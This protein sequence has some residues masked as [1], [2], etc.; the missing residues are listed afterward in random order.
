MMNLSYRIYHVWKRN[1]VSYKRYIIPTL[2]VSLG[3]PLFFLL[4][5]GVGLG[6]YIGGFG[7]ISY[8][9]FL[10]S[11][12][13]IIS[14]LFSAT[15]E[16]LY[17]TFVRMV[18][19]KLFSALIVTPVSCEDIVAGEIA[20][21]MTRAGISGVLMYVIALFLGVAPT[22]PII[23]I[24]LFLLVLSVGFVFSSFS[25]IVTSFAPHIDFFSYY[26][27]LFITPMFFFSGI[28]FP[29][30][31]MPDVVKMASSFIPL[32]HAVI[33]SRALFMEM[34]YPNLIWHFL[35]LLIPGII[36]FYI[37]LIFMKRRIIK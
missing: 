9:K 34:V 17:G 21:G 1:L 23:V 3:E 14:A 8:L 33:I 36:A 37:A 10:A 2:L 30:D 11:G 5:L 35:A 4:A 28:F 20:W 15:F 12:V 27:T 19:E 7:G 6:S 25:M 29:L 24:M 13:I 16:C 32:S 22:N 31:K 26:T 18:H